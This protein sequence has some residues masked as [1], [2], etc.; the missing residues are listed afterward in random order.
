[1][2]ATTSPEGSKVDE[3]SGY[4]SHK[5]P[6]LS[7]HQQEEE[8][9]II[10]L[11]GSSDDEE[12]DYEIESDEIIPISD[13]AAEE[14][15]ADEGGPQQEEQQEQ[16]K[17]VE[18]QSSSGKCIKTGH[19]KAK[20]KLDNQKKSKSSP[21]LKSPDSTKQHE[22]I[23]KPNFNPN[24]KIPK[25]VHLTEEQKRR[26]RDMPEYAREQG[27]K[28]LEEEFKVKFE[29]LWNE[30]VLEVR[31]DN[32]M[33]RKEQIV[34]EELLEMKD[35]RWN[36]IKNLKSDEERLSFAKEKFRSPI[37]S[38]PGRNLSFGGF[39]L[40]KAEQQQHKKV[41]EIL[42]ERN[43][44]F[45]SNGSLHPLSER[46]EVEARIK[47]VKIS[48]VRDR[49]KTRIVQILFEEGVRARKL[50]KPVEE[51]FRLYF[52]HLKKGLEEQTEF[53]KFYSNQQ[54]RYLL[55]K[56]RLW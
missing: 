8:V 4:V 48:E 17:P 3:D 6:L 36:E 15:T 5:S 43:T 29:E 1:M 24:Y 56:S 27:E 2:P 47:K 45:I 46:T 21:I 33:P 41:E 28:E 51:Q 40:K 35:E 13:K 7:Q 26:N 52:A 34:G 49:M 18:A 38:D 14:P 44:Q 37:T 12:E 10:E 11:L 55:S 53:L 20:H 31:P 50:S 22:V 16:P 30:S 42:E 39:K 19:V 25:N 54:V 9:S 32:G 23:K